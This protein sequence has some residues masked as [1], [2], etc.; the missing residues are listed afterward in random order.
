MV[1][2]E[3]SPNMMMPQGVPIED[4][5]LQFQ[6]ELQVVQSR[7]RS[8]TACVGGYIFES[9]ADTLK[10]VTDNCSSEDCKYVMDMP[11]LYILVCPDGQEYDVLL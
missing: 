8:D 4:A 9:Y 5:V 7:L 6:I 1:L 3:P 11:S 2:S 10:W